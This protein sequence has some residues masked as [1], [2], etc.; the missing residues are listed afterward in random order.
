MESV[1]SLIGKMDRWL[2]TNRTDYYVALK[3]GATESA[4]DAF[5]SQFGIK[6]P[7][8]FRSIYRWRNGQRDDCTTSLEDNF[9][10][11]SLE[12]IAENKET[13][14]GMIESD[15]DDPK[16][17]RRSWVPFLD[18]GG[19]DHLC[20]DLSAEDGGTPGQILSFY[21]DWENRPIQFPSAEA[22]LANIV[23]SMEDGSLK[24]A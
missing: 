9:M 15:F 17:W 14:D 12:S 22:W 11:S 3:P 18:N 2:A 24:I 6:L 16:W 5:E 4:L 23:Q 10:F 1:D 20:I 21:H 19:G 7:V 13:M 8:A